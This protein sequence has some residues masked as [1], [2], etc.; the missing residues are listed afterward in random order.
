MKT[1][2]HSGDLGDIILSLPAVSSLGG[3]IL[4]LDPEGGEDEELVSWATYTRTKLNKESI[5]A[6]KPLLEKQDYIEEV[7][8]WNPSIKVDYNLDEFRKHVKFNNLTTSHLA[9]FDLFHKVD[10]WQTTKW[11]D[12][13][14]KELPNNKK[15]ILSRSC[16][17]HSNYSFWESLGEG[18]IKDSVFV[19]HPKEFEYFL[20]TFPRYKGKIEFLNTENIEDLAGYIKFC[21][22]FI[23]NQSFTYCLAEAMKKKLVLEVYKTYPSSLFKREDVNYV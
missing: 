16:R 3:G 5:L 18:Y 21:D 20:Y 6:L 17:Y 15:I 23:G 14:P 22:L 9:A 12:V 4:Y 11:L 2:K 13:E 1:F 10:E 19:S 8:L 7:R